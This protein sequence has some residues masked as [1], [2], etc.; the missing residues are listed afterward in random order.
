M[1]AHRAREKSLFWFVSVSLC[2]WGRGIAVVVRR[3]VCVGD[4]GLAVVVR[5]IIAVGLFDSHLWI[6]YN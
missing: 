6:I 5:R 1:P 2:R 3:K 4:R